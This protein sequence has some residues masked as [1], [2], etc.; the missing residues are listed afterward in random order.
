M[1]ICLSTLRALLLAA[2]D[3]DGGELQEAEADHDREAW[4]ERV[5]S[6]S[7]SE[8]IG[9]KEAS[10]KEVENR[11]RKDNEGI[12]EGK[13]QCGKEE[14]GK[15]ASL[16]IE[17]PDQAMDHLHQRLSQLPQQGKAL[18]DNRK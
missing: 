18:H 6:I 17:G 9:G 7:E 12:G 2:A 5:R 8:N 15:K 11:G 3:V 16:N 13:D 10:S 1:E 4:E 14:Q